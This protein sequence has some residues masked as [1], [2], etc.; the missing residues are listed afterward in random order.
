ML[1]SHSLFSSRLTDA[2]PQQREFLGPHFMT[3]SID[4][5]SIFKMSIFSLEGNAFN[6]QQ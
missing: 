5:L 1:H 3:T 4:I 6:E 2:R